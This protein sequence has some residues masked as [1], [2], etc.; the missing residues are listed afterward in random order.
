M[1][2]QASKTKLTLWVS[3]EVKQIGRKLSRKTRSSLSELF[4][5]YLRRVK[6]DDKSSVCVSPLVKSL[7]GIA[8]GKPLKT[9]DYKA[10]LEKKYL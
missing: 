5:S 7:S 4:S 9:S 2:K 1:I 6:A 10:H 3:E 8:K